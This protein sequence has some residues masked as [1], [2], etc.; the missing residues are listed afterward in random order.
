MS[1]FF[2]SLRR[3]PDRYGEVFREFAVHLVFLTA[4]GLAAEKRRHRTPLHEG[5]A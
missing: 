1:E 5:V 4:A 2:R 3:R